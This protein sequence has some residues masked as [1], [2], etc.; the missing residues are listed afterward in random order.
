MP[1]TACPRAVFVGAEG[2]EKTNLEGVLRREERG[3]IGSIGS[4]LHAKK[5][6]KSRSFPSLHHH[7]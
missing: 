2:N 5:R 7:Y 1:N 6:V 3:E 4:I